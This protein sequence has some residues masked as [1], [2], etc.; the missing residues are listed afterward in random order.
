MP[1]KVASTIEQRFGTTLAD[2]LY[3][4]YWTEQ[5]STL[6]IAERLGVS[7]SAVRKWMMQCKIPRRD[8][9]GAQQVI[10]LKG[11]RPPAR[12]TGLVGAA[13]PNW[14]GGRVRHTKGYVLAYAPEHPEAVGGYV[15]EHRLVAE[16]M[17]G[18][19]LRA[20]EDVHHKDGDK[21]N[22]HPSNLEVLNHSEHARHHAALKSAGSPLDKRGSRGLVA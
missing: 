7:A 14:K 6:A 20:D 9:C 16:E 1:R 12:P 5:Q 13:N 8:A 2:L 18:R 21:M 3:S 17:L 11:R 19:R 4:L 10:K 15:L 22:N